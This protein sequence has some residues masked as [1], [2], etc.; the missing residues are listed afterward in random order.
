MIETR[1]GIL[2][3]I[4]AVLVAWFLASARALASR[5]GVPNLTFTSAALGSNQALDGV[6]YDDIVSVTVTPRRDQKVLIFAAI[7]DV[8]T[9]DTTMVMQLF[10]DSTSLGFLAFGMYNSG[11]VNRH[12]STAVVVSGLL[13]AGTSYTFKITANGSTNH[14]IQATLTKIGVLWAED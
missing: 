5:T 8:C 7:Q 12:G 14:T 11:G 2:A 1:R 9:D 3:T 13:T 10:Q 6:G 4:F